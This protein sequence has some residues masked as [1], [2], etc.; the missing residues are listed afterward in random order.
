VSGPFIVLPPLGSPVDQLWHVLLDLAELPVRWTLIGGQMVLLHALEHGR[1]PPQISQDGDVIADIR[2]DQ[3][4]LR[5]VVKALT[6][7][8]FDLEAITTDGRAHRY[9]RP[10]E[11]RPVVVDVLAPDGL[12]LKTKLTTT[13]PGRTIEVPA[14]TQALDRTESVEIRHEG[15]TG[16]I[17]RPSL[18]GAIVSKGRACT[19]PGDR[20][21]HERDLALL[22][23]LVTDP[24]EMREQIGSTDLRR[25]RGART[26]AN[27]EDRAWRLV[28]ADIRQ[29]GIAA[30]GILTGGR[31]S[32][33]G[34]RRN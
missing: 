9:V 25:I 7:R 29:Q 23:A 24:F 10:A 26:L 12:G 27:P 28:P 17:P 3:T 34:Q 2:A 32:E 8:G 13:P 20:S 19:L 15:R 16:L 18:L 30:F 31:G 33:R 1:V 14:G 21:R 11:P 4:A 5:T 6:D 22:C